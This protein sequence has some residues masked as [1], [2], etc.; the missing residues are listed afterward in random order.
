MSSAVKVIASVIGVLAIFPSAAAA[1][2]FVDKR[3]HQAK[4]TKTCTIE[5]MSGSYLEKQGN[6]YR[7]SPKL[8]VEKDGGVLIAA[9]EETYP[10][11]KVYFLIA[12]HR[13]S[14]DAGYFTRLDRS[15]VDA[16]RKQALLQFTFT[17]WPSRT[18]ISVD[19]IIDGFEKAYNECR[20]FLGGA[21]NPLGPVSIAPRT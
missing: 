19:D 12:G 11:T 21:A 13:Y 2:I 9:G 5:Q 18:E 15:A 16:L 3:D 4:G 1:G 20:Q 14:G 7:K 8:R 10:G 17:R 6:P